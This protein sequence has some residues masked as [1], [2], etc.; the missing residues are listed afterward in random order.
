MIPIQYR[1]EGTDEILGHGHEPEIPSIGERR[2][3]GVREYEVL[4]R[5]RCGPTCCTV[6]VRPVAAGMRIAS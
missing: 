4:Y 5:W 1:E 6:Y 3:L 2:W